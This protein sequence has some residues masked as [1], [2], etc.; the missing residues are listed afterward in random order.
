LKRAPKGFFAG[1][2]R[3]EA[4]AQKYGADSREDRGD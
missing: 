1:Q 4:T 2:E 3:A